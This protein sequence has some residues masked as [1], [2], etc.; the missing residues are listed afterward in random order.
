MTPY[1]R[2]R[3]V[4]AG[5]VVLFLLSAANIYFE[6]GF[7]PRFARAIM[8]LSFLGTTVFAVRFVIASQ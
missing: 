2:T 7:L 3:V 4:A 8:G 5:V 6:L 1:N